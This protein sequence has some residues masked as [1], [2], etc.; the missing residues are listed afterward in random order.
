MKVY[1]VRTRGGAAGGE[2][3]LEQEASYGNFS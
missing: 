1:F 2:N 3:H